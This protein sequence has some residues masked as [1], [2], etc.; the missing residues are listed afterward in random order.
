VVATFEQVAWGEPEPEAPE[1]QDGGPAARLR[2][3]WQ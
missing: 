2:A 3:R 1:A